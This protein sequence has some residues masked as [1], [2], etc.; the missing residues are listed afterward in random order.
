MPMSLFV[1]LC[2]LHLKVLHDLY[3]AK[4]KVLYVCT[5]CTVYE[6]TTAVVCEQ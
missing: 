4:C 1:P 2:M 5:A 3:V 6:L